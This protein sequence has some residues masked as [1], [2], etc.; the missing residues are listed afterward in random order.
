MQKPL[1]FHFLLLLVLL[2]LSNTASASKQ[3]FGL[4]DRNHDGWLAADEIKVEHRRLYQ[5]LLRTSDNDQDGRLSSEE[6]QAGIQ[7]QLP[8]KPLVKKQ[9][10]ELPGAN[11]L[12]LL[13]AK[14]DTNSDGQIEKAEVPEAFLELFDRIEDRL[15]GEHDGLLDRREL[16]QSA[17]R[18]SQIALRI[19]ERMDLDVEV[20]LALLPE[21][22]W[23]SVQNMLNQRSRGD[24]LA[25]PKRARQL[26]RQLD[27]N[28]DG[29]ITSAE[30]PDQIAERFELLLE[31]ADHD[32]NEKISESELMA[33]SRQLQAREA[34]RPSP[35]QIEKGIKRLLKKWDR[36]GDRQLSR[37][38]VPRRMA[39]RFEQ[40]D[41]DGNGRLDRDELV[42]VVELLSR[43][44]ASEMQPVG[45]SD[46]M[47]LPE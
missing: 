27:R 45:E 42:P 10:N 2:T 23:R 43:I 31:R 37:K 32:H 46:T 7:P 40:I 1:A 16:T 6:F 5:R 35:K 21:K 22:K 44:R 18:L 34:N 12:L 3:L 15:G 39:D 47:M 28:G 36:N 14:M 38:E 41:R 24:V 26:F 4:L 8:A 11:A 30:V 17:P 29:Q 9:S 19:A 25:D 20:E 13:V 33:V